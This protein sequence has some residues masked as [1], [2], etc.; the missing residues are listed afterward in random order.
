[1]AGYIHEFLKTALIE[2][3]FE[4]TDTNIKRL[5]P[6]VATKLTNKI[7][8]GAKAEDAGRHSCA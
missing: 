5:H 8:V 7:G 4:L 2:A 1:M 3:P 6:A